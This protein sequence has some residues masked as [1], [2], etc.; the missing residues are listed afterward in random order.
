[1]SEAAA[2]IVVCAVM[3]G[4]A[5]GSWP[6]LAVNRAGITVIG[7]ALLLALG[8]ITPA[9]AWAAIDIPT[10]VILV[11]MMV[12]NHVLE[13]TGVFA[14]A[15]QWLGQSVRHGAE[16]LALLM[17]LCAVLSALF[18]ND[19]VV[20]LLTPFVILLAQTLQIPVL[21]LLL[22]IATSANIG[23]ALTI[24]GNPQNIIIGNRSGIGFMAFATQMLPVVAASLVIAYVVVWWLFRRQLGGYTPSTRALVHRPQTRGLV[25]IALL[26]GLLCSG[27]PAA[28][29]VAMTAAT[30]L[31]RRR[32]PAEAVFTSIDSGL[33][34]FFAA[35][36]VVTAAFGQT[37]T[38]QWLIHTLS[39]GIGGS[40]SRV[41]FGTALLANLV[42]NVPAVLLLQP[43]ILTFPD[44]TKA[45]LV[46]AA[47]ST[48]AGNT[49]LLASVANLIVAERAQQ[50]GVR[51]DF[52]TY[53]RVGVP[54]TLC[55]LLVTIGWFAAR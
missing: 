20:F 54:V 7:A 49:T 10:L 6:G 39:D 43:V 19:T 30:A 35:L 14:A 51:M 18:L 26:T 25:T 24:T 2:V 45:W 4:I 11:G 53:T 34:I 22:G 32:T 27:V 31:V 13:E 9:A 38:A 16:L 37:Q 29:A 47:T 15:A 48:M 21:P 8:T 42:S 23:S 3:Y 5:R 41:G 55:T 46:L 17:L 36:F 52:W 40:L 12:I 50:A 44:P 33:L 28:A 1:M